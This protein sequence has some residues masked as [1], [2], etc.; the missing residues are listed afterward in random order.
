MSSPRKPPS[1]EDLMKNLNVKKDAPAPQGVKRE[2]LLANLRALAKKEAPPKPAP[3]SP[4]KVADP[5]AERKWAER[6][7]A[8]L[9]QLAEDEK[10][11]AESPPKSAPA[12]PRQSP[13]QEMPEQKQASPAP[14]GN[15]QQVKQCRDITAMVGGPEAILHKDPNN[16]KSF[17]LSVPIDKNSNALMKEL[18]KAGFQCEEKDG[19]MQIKNIT[20]ENLAKLAPDGHSQ[21]LAENMWGA[22]KQKAGE[23]QP[24]PASTGSEGPAQK[25]QNQ[26]RFRMGGG[27]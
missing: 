6:K 5:G 23:R 3:P 17:Y 25:S 16:N 2:E 7:A 15:I 18:K 27:Q 14:A 21:K 11:P 26:Q 20:K 8:L 22:V 13:R 19:R 1:K 24:E 10:K 4:R 12:S 9:A